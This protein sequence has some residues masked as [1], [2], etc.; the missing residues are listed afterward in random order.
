MTCTEA[1]NN[2]LPYIDGEASPPLARQIAEHLGYCHACAGWFAQQRRLEKAIQAR[3]LASLQTADLWDRVLT[4][5]GLIPQRRFRPGLLVGGL[6]GAVAVLVM[7]VIVAGWNRRPDLARAAAELHQGWL[8]GEVQPDF[9]ST[10]ELE[11][12]RYFKANAP[13]KVHCPP[14]SDVHFAVQGAGLQTLSHHR[15]GFI[16]GQVGEA[17]VSIVVLDRASLSAFPDDEARLVAGHRHHS[18]KAGYRSVSALVADNVVLVI[19]NTSPATLDRLLDAYGSY[20]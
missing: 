11:V 5:A 17:R 12:D 18:R 16:V 1:R 3:L 10:S 4:R 8:N 19:G 6:V 13:F 2:C 9:A 20:H 7:L 14:R 15:A